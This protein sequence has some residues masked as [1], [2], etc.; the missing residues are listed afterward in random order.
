MVR[1]KVLSITRDDCKWDYFRA[2]GKGGQSQNKTNTGAR[3]T[4]QPSGAVGESREYK[5]Q[6]QNRQA[7]WKKMANDPK[8]KAWIRRQSGQDLLIQS[9]VKKAMEPRNLKVEG[10]RDGLWVPLEEP[11]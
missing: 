2:G 6:W 9:A 3:V 10:K 4:H 11:S 1:Q 8:M 7:A 5:S